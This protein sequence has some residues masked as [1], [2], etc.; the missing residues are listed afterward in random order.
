MGGKAWIIAILIVVGSICLAYSE[1]D[2]QAEMRYIRQM[3]GKD[4]SQRAIVWQ[5]EAVDNSAVAQYRRQGDERASVVRPRIERCEAGDTIFFRYRADIAALPVDTACEYRV[6]SHSYQSEWRRLSAKKEEYTAV[7]FAD[8][9]CVGDYRTWAELVQAAR[10]RER[11]ASLCLH[12]GDLVDC[13]ASQ[14]QWE[15]WLMGAEEMLAEC[16]FAPTMGNHEDYGIDWQM[17]L[18]HYY[19]ALFP[20]VSA[21]DDMLDG[22]VYSFDYGDV[23]Y[24]VLDTQAEELAEWK[25]DWTAHQAEWLARDLAESGARWKV[26]LCH[27][28][29]YEIDGTMS[30]HGRAWLPICRRYG[31]QLVLSGHHHIYSREK[32][33]NITMITAGVSG[34]GTGYEPQKR[35][36]IVAL[37]CD[38]PNYLTMKVT[39]DTLHVRALQLDGTII[40]ETMIQHCQ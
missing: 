38:T 14:Y 30:E 35:Q 12:L 24:A 26:V 17:S 33:G 4:A 6:V 11:D 18:P 21:G 28:P 36:E 32:T 19:R 37:R 7:I 20:V 29:F 40:D 1:A 2:T 31:V 27:K 5:S 25:A 22:H 23:H 34:D 15:R 39:D 16:A 10:E 3:V 13:G 9:Q 8:S